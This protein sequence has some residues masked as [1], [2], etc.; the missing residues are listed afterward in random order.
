MSVYS[1]KDKGWRYDFTLKGK[2]YTSNW[3]KTRTQA[4]MAETRKR[5][6]VANAA[7]VV[8]PPKVVN[9][10][11]VVD[12]PSPPMI[13]E[14]ETTPTDMAFLDL[15]NRRLDY[16]KTYKS[17]TYYVQHVHMARRLGRKWP[18]VSCRQIGPDMVQHYI[19]QRGSTAP[20]A[21]N[22][23]LRCLRAL[24]NFGI[25]LGLIQTNPTQGLEFIPVER[26]LRYVPPKEDLAKVL[27]AAD[28]ETQDYLLTIIDTLARVGEINR[29]TWSDVN[30]TGKYVVLYTRKKRGGH[31]TPRKV[32]M[33]SRL[34][35]MLLKRFRQ[36]DPGKPWVFWQRAWSRREGKW[37][38]GPYQ[39][40]K[41]LMG[42]LCRKAGVRPFAFHALRH[43]GASMLDQAKVPLGAIQRIL[44]H[45]SRTTT[46]IYLHAMGEAER[47][48]MEIFEKVSQEAAPEGQSH[49][50]SHIDSHIKSH[51]N[52]H[53]TPPDAKGARS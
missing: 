14:V 22:K 11:E 44:G 10:P 35:T 6:E 52:S 53:K 36:R 29:L 9:P 21:A 48:A 50:N 37:A 33:T 25:R 16:I 41:S 46:E 30:F 39:Y 13:R 18:G 40:R 20:S 24:F 4:Y 47:E 43:F 34:H 28:P 17:N 2:R 49:I 1:I 23:E 31:L 19:A 5:E 26:R 45:E 15:V 8:D 38:T 3:F 42:T 12:P 7:E 27:L 51:I 32:A